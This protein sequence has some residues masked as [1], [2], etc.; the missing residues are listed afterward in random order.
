MEPEKVRVVDR[1]DCRDIG[2]NQKLNL[3][4][5]INHNYKN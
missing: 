2:C 1:N 5:F 4:I 3:K